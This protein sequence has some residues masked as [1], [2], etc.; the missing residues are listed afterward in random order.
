MREMQVRRKCLAS[1]VR[2][3][4]GSLS[5]SETSY[6]VTTTKSDASLSG[7]T[8]TIHGRLFLATR[9]MNRRSTVRGSNAVDASSIAWTSAALFHAQFGVRR[10]RQLPIPPHWKGRLRGHL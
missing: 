8:I 6:A 10:E 9:I 1:S 4:K 7:S 5:H 2:H 3:L